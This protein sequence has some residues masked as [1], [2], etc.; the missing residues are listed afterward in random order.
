MSKFMREGFRLLR[1][2]D[3]NENLHKVAA[4]EVVY[5]RGY[6]ILLQGQL[7]DKKS[8]YLCPPKRG[9]MTP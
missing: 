5:Q 2:K 7:L 4:N 1:G 3:N 9:K 6:K 8:V